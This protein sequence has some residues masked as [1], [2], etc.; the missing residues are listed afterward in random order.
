[1]IMTHAARN[2]AK[3][4]KT[5]FENT[6]YPSC[7]DIK[8]RNSISKK[9]S[10]FQCIFFILTEIGFLP[11]EG[12]MRATSASAA[13]GSSSGG[14]SDGRHSWPLIV[15]ASSPCAADNRETRFVIALIKIKQG[16]PI[17]LQ[18]AGRRRGK[19]WSLIAFLCKRWT[20]LII[21][22]TARPNCLVWVFYASCFVLPFT[23]TMAL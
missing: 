11:S 8:F 4:K 12:R 6:I 9:T 2:A 3:Q 14:C 19:T 22:L 23:W 13:S 16:N 21:P 1:M 7:R 17:F 10:I 20:L 5:A 18:L 15:S